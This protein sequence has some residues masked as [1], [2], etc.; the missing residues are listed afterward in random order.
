MATL[1]ALMD[2]AGYLSFD[3]VAHLFRLEHADTYRLLRLYYRTH[4]DAAAAERSR[5][6]NKALGGW[7]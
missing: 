2:A 7:Y 6:R 5:L 3:E 1:I 4:P